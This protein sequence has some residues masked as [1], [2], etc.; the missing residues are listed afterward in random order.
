MRRHIGQSQQ[1]SSLW[2]LE[3]RAERAESEDNSSAP[4]AQDAS[5]WHQTPRHI[6][7]ES[8]THVSYE[9]QMEDGDADASGGKPPFA[10]FAQE[11]FS[12]AVADD[13]GTNATSFERMKNFQDRMGKDSYAPF[14]DHDEWELARWLMKNVNQKGTDEFLKLPIVSYRPHKFTT[15]TKH[16][17]VKTKDRVRPSFSSSYTFLKLID[18]LPTGPEWTCRKIRTHGDLDPIESDTPN[19]PLDGNTES[20][21]LELWMRDPVACIRELIGNPSFNGNMAYAPEKVYMDQEGQTR[22]YDEMWT[23]DWWWQTQVRRPLMLLA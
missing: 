22:R 14:A 6:E 5:M 18:Q 23:G 20:E 7:E 2:E 12:H 8:R 13:L 11:F 3:A 10:R 17:I 9:V 19:S 4:E 21:E 1:C 16:T 15:G